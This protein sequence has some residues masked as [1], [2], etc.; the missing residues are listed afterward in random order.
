MSPMTMLAENI[1][2][3]TPKTSIVLD[4]EKGKEPQFVYYGQRL[5]AQD[6]KNLPAAT[7][8]NWSNLSV[9]PAYGANHIQWQTA[10][11]MT[12]ADGNMSTDLLI[13]DYTTTSVCEQAPN[14]KTRKGQLL[15]I[16]LKDPLYPSRVHL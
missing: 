15:T 16:T 2:L 9:Y 12:H 7:T 1:S 13:E 10:F 5:S 8:A 11:A 4:L 3:S 14:G 6:L